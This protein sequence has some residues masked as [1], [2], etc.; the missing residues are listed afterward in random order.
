M[1]QEHRMPTSGLLALIEAESQLLSAL[2][3][4]RAVS[5]RMGDHDTADAREADMANDARAALARIGH[6]ISTGAHPEDALGRITPETL[7]KRA[8]EVIRSAEAA[9]KEEGLTLQLDPDGTFQLLD[10]EGRTHH[11]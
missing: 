9:A 3:T 2:D 8:W 5:R 4:A 7:R 10:E 1:T 11:D 6:A